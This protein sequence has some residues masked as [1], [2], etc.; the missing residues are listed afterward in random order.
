M[1]AKFTKFSSKNCN[2]SGL[3]TNNLL[4]I[5]VFFKKSAKGFKAAK[6]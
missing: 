1:Q 2:A 4:K 5:R 3:N 6:L